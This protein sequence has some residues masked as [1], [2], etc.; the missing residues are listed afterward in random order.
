VRD[1]QEQKNICSCLTLILAIIIY[2]QAKEIKHVVDAYGDELEPDCL[3]ML[4]H[5][6]PIGWDNV[7]LYGEYLIDK[8]LIK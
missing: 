7:L 4:P 8:K 2:W 6:R 3:A 1:L 5:I